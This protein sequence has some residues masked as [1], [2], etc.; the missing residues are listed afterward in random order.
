MSSRAFAAFTDAQ[1]TVR[2]L[3]PRHAAMRWLTA[4][5]YMYQV[6]RRHTDELVHAAIPTIE[7]V[8]GGGVRCMMAE[9]F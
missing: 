7:T 1:L 9:I 2:E 4:Q 5:R 3:R 6:L 8:G